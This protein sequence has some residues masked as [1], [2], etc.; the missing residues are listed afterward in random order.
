MMPLD[1]MKLAEQNRFWA[2]V[3]KTA[4]CWFWTAAKTDRGYGSFCNRF[5]H[6]IG[7]HIF[8]YELHKGQAYGY[9]CH[10]CDNPACVNP[11]HLFLG[12]QLDNMGDC[13]AKGRNAI[14]YGEQNGRSKLTVDVVKQIKAKAEWKRG[15]KA[16]MARQLGVSHTVIKDIIQGN[17]WSHV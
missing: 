13:R 4:T 10:T 5:G 7:A 17:R 3:Q 15:E 9:V 14:H 8:S 1:E 6:T 12:S 16:A 11:D 2:K